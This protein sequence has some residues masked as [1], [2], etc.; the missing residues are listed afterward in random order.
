MPKY[1][2]KCPINYEIDVYPKC[3]YNCLY[4]I[5]KT[6]PNKNAFISSDLEKIKNKLLSENKE[7]YP[8]YLSPWTDS[9]PTSEEKE[10]RTERILSFLSKNHF[11][12]FV[13]TKGNLILRDKNF[14]KAENTFAAI[15]L[16]TLENDIIKMLEPDVPSVTERK[17]LI[18]ELVKTGVRTVVKIDPIIPGITDGKE[19]WELAYWL[20]KLKPTAVTAET[21]R[22]NKKLERD[23]KE[24]IPEEVF[25]NFL[26]KYEEITDEPKH[27]NLEYRLSL[28]RNLAKLFEENG[29]KASFCKASLPYPITPHDCRGGY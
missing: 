2:G 25:A 17:E 1:E 29:V 13:I 7:R 11:P 20:C 3:R 24:A 15:S 23:I 16:N 9:Y 26:S 14:F 19:L 21:L 8:V 22:I 6:E 12:Y 27:P 28:F 18:E 4:C 10:R 5:S